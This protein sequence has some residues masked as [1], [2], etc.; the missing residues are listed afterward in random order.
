MS[1][2]MSSETSY[3][4]WS[5]FELLDFTPEIDLGLELN[6]TDL[7]YIMDNPQNG[8]I[9]DIYNTFDNWYENKSSSIEKSLIGYYFIVNS[10]SQLRE[11]KLSIV[12]GLKDIYLG[13]T[14]ETPFFNCFDCVEEKEHN[15]PSNSLKEIFLVKNISTSL[16]NKVKSFLDKYVDRY[17]YL[18][19]NI[20]HS[21]QEV[22]EYYYNVRFKDIEKP[23]SERFDFDEE[24]IRELKQNKKIVT[25]K[26][27]KSIKKVFN[28]SL[29]ILNQF[30]GNERT[31]IFI[32][33]N[34]FKLEGKLY[35]YVLKSKGNLLQNTKQMNNMSIQYDLQILNKENEY[36]S[37]LCVVFPDC[38]I[39]DEVLSV[40]LM[41]QSG[42]EEDLLKSSNFFNRNEELLY[43]D[44]YICSLKG[45]NKSKKNNSFSD[46][47]NRIGI[48]KSKKELIFDNKRKDLMSKIERNLFNSCDIPK[49]IQNELFNQELSFDEIVDYVGVN[50]P[51]PTHMD[52]LNN[53]PIIII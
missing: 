13:N 37:K 49:V 35:N 36:L 9:N 47:L 23:L 20:N 4:F 5:G 17:N 29:K 43:K 24:C 46:K 42:K 1:I 48:V 50:I 7:D 8:F 28:K 19:S 32:K 53:K 41:I 27:T 22:M 15:I 38:P 18:T 21:F 30:L 16:D 39:L 3:C 26:E 6:D 45:F 40:Y 2:K 44:D 12:N 25:K 14:K 52:F 34:E 51:T 33:G 31:N 11:V 10:H